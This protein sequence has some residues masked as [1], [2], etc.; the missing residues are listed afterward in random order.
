MKYTL[1][2]LLLMLLRPAQADEPIEFIVNSANPASELSSIDIVDYYLKKRRN[3]SNGNGVRFIDRLD[4]SSERSVFLKN[5]IKRS[6]R[7]VELY[8]IG[9][10]IA[11]GN[12]SPLQAPSD[13]AVEI[14][15]SR[16]PGAIGYVSGSFPTGSSVKKIKITG[17]N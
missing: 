17:L 7:D 4:D 15:V 2:I 6:S 14:L 5:F 13:L 1:L 16:F 11:T 12:S 8:W 3:W 10:K 9:Q